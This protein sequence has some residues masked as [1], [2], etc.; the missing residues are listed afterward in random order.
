MSDDPTIVPTQEQ[1]IALALEELRALGG[2]TLTVHE[3]TCELR[4]IEAPTL[5]DEERCGCEV[6]TIQVGDARA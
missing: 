2:G 3:D 5:E 6:L 1:A 4:S